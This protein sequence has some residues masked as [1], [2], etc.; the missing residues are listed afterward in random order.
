MASKR[1]SELLSKVLEDIGVSEKMI[2]RRKITFAE[3]EV[4]DSLSVMLLGGKALSLRFGSQI[5]GSTTLGMDSDLDCLSYLTHWPVILA[6]EDWSVGK[7]NL[8]LLSNQQCPPQHCYL[9]RLRE[10]APEP[11]TNL[12]VF[13]HAKDSKER[14]LI[15]NTYVS[16]SAKRLIKKV[17][18]RFI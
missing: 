10:D 12:P 2:N 11:L 1:A 15:K 3:V 7:K 17:G 9:Q 18:K 8:L 5:E 14:V 4:V 16:N 6:T 13:D